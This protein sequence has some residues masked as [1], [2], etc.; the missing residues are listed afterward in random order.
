MIPFLSHHF[1]PPL[2][3]VVLAIIGIVVGTLLGLGTIAFINFLCEDRFFWDEEGEYHRIG[4][5]AVIR[6]NGTKEWWLHGQRH[7]KDGPAITYKDGSQE[8]YLH[9][10]RHRED[11]PALIEPGLH[12]YYYH[13]KRHRTDGP[14][15]I[16]TYEYSWCLD[17]RCYDSYSN[18]KPRVSFQDTKFRQPTQAFRHALDQWHR[19]QHADKYL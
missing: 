1:L 7:R 15:V 8:W 17:D 16:S 13:G 2:D 10:R 5:P 12:Q 19:E 18:L 9:G 4:K 3:M 14:A 6:K 11:G